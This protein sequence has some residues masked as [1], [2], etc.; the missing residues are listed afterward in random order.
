MAHPFDLPSDQLAKALVR[1]AGVLLLPATMFV[2]EDDPSG[3]R[4]LRIAFANLDRDGI[5]QMFQRLKG[6][7]F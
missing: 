7:T 3:Q 5:G 6:L 2:P 4:H 1:E